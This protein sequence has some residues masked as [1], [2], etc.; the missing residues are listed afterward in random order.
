MFSFGGNIDSLGNKFMSLLSQYEIF[1]EGL[2]SAPLRP[3]CCQWTASA[4]TSLLIIVTVNDF[5]LYCWFLLIIVEYCRILLIIVDFCH[6]QYQCWE[7]LNEE[8]WLSILLLLIL[9]SGDF[10]FV[11]VWIFIDAKIN[12][13]I[14]SVHS[15]LLFFLDSV[16]LYATT[17]YKT[18]FD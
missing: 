6:R 8:R 1:F 10:S 13:H 15:L 9:Q 12:S 5:C 7:L 14:K 16:F 2:P 18:E 3:P 11:F 4:P 17:A